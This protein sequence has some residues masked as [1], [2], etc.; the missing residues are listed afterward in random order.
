M[1][2]NP[3]NSAQLEGTPYHSPKLHPTRADRQTDTHTDTQTRVTNI[4][5]ASATSRA[6]CNKLHENNGSTV[7][8]ICDRY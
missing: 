3:P 4:H 8:V 7:V 5:F 6:E 2:A 1:I